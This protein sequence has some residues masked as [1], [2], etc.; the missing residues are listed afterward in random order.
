MDADVIIKNI[1]EY[2]HLNEQSRIVILHDPVGRQRDIAEAYSI[3]NLWQQSYHASNIYPLTIGFYVEK[4]KATKNP[5]LKKKID[6]SIHQDR[7]NNDWPKL[8]ET[9]KDFEVRQAKLMKLFEAFADNPDLSY[10]VGRLK[11]YFHY[12]FSLQDE[13]ETQEEED[14]LESQ[15]FSEILSGLL[16]NLQSSLPGQQILAK[17][18][19]KASDSDGDGKF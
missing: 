12:F 18:A 2:L 10:Q 13:K 8:K 1:N 4:L 9:T 5:E 14:A 7:W 16:G 15:F 11:N 3:L 19:A 6:D 17:L